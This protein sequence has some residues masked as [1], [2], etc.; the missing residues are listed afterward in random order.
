[1]A[2][3]STGL[4][5]L[6]GIVSIKVCRMDKVEDKKPMALLAFFKW[7]VAQ[8]RF[9]LAFPVSP[10]RVRRLAWAP[11]CVLTRCAASPIMLLCGPRGP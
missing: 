10:C 11:F 9:D 3:F 8:L 6:A 5:K 2:P 4:Q 1:M 7:L